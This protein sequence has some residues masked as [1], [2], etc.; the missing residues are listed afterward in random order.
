MGFGMGAAIGAA[1]A[2]K[3]SP[4]LF[5]SDGSFHMNLNEL[6]TAVKYKC[7]LKI[8]LFNNNV[9]GM[10]RQWQTMFYGGRYSSTELNLPTD[11]VSLARAF[12]AEAFTLNKNDDIKDVVEKAFATE[13]TVLVNCVIGRDDTVFP[14]IPPG[15]SMDEII[16][17][18]EDV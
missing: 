15:K 9:L 2:T 13:N 11:Y 5:T 12:G 18:R 10:V 17:K 1:F 7:A 3:K 4:V 16:E 8:F 6:A 14:M